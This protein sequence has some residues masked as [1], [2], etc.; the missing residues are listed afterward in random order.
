MIDRLW[1]LIPELIMLAGAGLVL[2]LDKLAGK[3]KAPKA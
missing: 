2:L 3:H 1:F